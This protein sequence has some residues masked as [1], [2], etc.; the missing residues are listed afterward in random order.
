[1]KNCLSPII[2]IVG[3]RWPL[4]FDPDPENRKITWGDTIVLDVV[5]HKSSFIPPV[6]LF[7]PKHG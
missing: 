4:T 6:K 2:A 7:E 3:T 5:L 1:M